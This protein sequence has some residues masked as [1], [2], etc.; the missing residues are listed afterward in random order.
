MRELDDLSQDVVAGGVVSAFAREGHLTDFT[1]ETAPDHLKPYFSTVTL[2]RTEGDPDLYVTEAEPLVAYILSVTPP[3]VRVD[4][5]KVAA[6]RARVDEALAASG[7]VR[8]T[9]ATGLFEAR[10]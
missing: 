9:R 6:L 3:E 7:E 8:V 10:R 5:T 4:E 2:H 1:L